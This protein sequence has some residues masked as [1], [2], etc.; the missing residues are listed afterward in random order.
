MNII[1]LKRP[2]ENIPFSFNNWQTIIY[3]LR[4]LILWN[5]ILIQWNYTMYFS[6]R[7]KMFSPFNL[8]LLTVTYDCRSPLTNTIL[9][10]TSWP[11]WRPNIVDYSSNF[12][13]QPF[14]TGL[15]YKAVN[16]R[17]SLLFPYRF[18]FIRAYSFKRQ[19]KGKS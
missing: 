6:W 9:T 18:P 4:F 10:L 3:V 1:C 12:D 13:R 19:G 17:E 16:L 8:Y 5:L 7:M 2:S 11:K 15:T 14:W